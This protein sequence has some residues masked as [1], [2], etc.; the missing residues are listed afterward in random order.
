MLLIARF[1]FFVLAYIVLKSVW[2][3]LDT[4]TDWY[5]SNKDPLEIVIG[6]GVAYF[7]YALIRIAFMRIG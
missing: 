1:V 4:C 5:C 7:G 6:I 3:Q 2:L